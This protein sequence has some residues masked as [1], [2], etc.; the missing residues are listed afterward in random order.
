MKITPRR[1]IKI[2]CRICSGSS[3]PCQSPHCALN[4]HGTSLWQ[5]KRHCV[6]CAPDHKVDECTGRIVGAQAEMHIAA[7]CEKVQDAPLVAMCPLFPYRHG[8]NPNRSAANR[9]RRSADTLQGYRFQ[10]KQPLGALE[11]PVGTPHA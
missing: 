2:T 5:I 8:K 1:A 7:G 10:K 3:E 6:N 9:R 4:R 11:C